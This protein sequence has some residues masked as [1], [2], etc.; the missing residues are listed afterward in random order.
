MPPGILAVPLLRALASGDL[1]AA[2]DLGVLGLIEED[3]MALNA[4]LRGHPDY[5]V[6]LRQ[7]L[8]ELEATI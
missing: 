7:T 6:L 2:R 5:R 3:L 4:R 8:D 1:T